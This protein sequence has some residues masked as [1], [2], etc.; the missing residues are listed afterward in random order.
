MLSHTAMDTAPKG[1]DG[2]E[3]ADDYA[4][5]AAESAWDATDRRCLREASLAH[6]TRKTTEARTQAT[7]EW[8]ASH[9]SSRR[10]KLPRGNIIRPALRKEQI[11]LAGRYYQFLLGHAAWP[12]RSRRS[13]R[14]SVGGAA[15]FPG[16]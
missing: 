8:I 4:K 16:I 14:M 10:H 12:T 11:E 2:N 3:V 9:K 13:C 15:W 6:P 5:V 1:V 7:R